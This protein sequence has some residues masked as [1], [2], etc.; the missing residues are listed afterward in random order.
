MSQQGDVRQRLRVT[1]VVQGVGFR[2]TVYQLATELGL[3]GLVGNDSAGVFIE[4][5]GAPQAIDDFVLRLQADPPPLAATAGS[6]VV[7]A[8]VRRPERDPI[9]V[10]SLE[11]I[12]ES[13]YRSAV[14]GSEGA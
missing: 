3:A 9:L 12:L 10:L 5:E 6:G 14:P 11:H 8:V 2:P 7:R 13:V 1:G 4:L